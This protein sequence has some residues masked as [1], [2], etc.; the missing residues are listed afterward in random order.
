M[1]CIIDPHTHH[2]DTTRT[3]PCTCLNMGGVQK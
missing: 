3:L 1:V 2:A